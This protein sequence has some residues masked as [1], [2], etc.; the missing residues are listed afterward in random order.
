[1]NVK[2]QKLL[3]VVIIIIIFAA[4]SFI[5]WQYPQSNHGWIMSLIG[6]FILIVLSAG[7][8][9]LIIKGIDDDYKSKVASLG[10]K[11]V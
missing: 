11:K 4:F 7:V 2:Y 1:M 6:Q 5:V 8:G 3:T 10:E 9:I